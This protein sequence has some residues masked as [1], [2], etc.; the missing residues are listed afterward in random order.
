MSEPII[1]NPG[2]AVQAASM[3]SAIRDDGDA[4]ETMPG[5]IRVKR[6]TRMADPD[7]AVD[8]VVKSVQANV[9]DVDAKLLTIKQGRGGRRLF[10]SNHYPTLA[11]YM[12]APQIRKR[13][14]E[15]FDAGALNDLNDRIRANVKS[16]RQLRE[17]RAMGRSVV[18]AMVK[19]GKV[20]KKVLE[21][22]FYM[23]LYSDEAQAAAGQ[24]TVFP[25]QDVIL[26]STSSPSGK[27]QLWVD[28]LDMHR[29]S[30]EAA[31]RNPIGK[32]ICDIIPQFVLGR[33]LVGDIKSKP[34]QEAW[35]E[36]Y[37]RERLRSRLRVFLKE[38]L[39][40]GEI[41]LR[42]FKRPDGLV[43]RS[44]DPSSIWDVVTSPEDFEDVYY[45]HQQYNISNTSPVPGA[46]IYPAKLVIRQIPAP[47]ID[48]FKIN[49]VSSEKRGRSQLYSILGYLLRFKEFANDRVL[50]NK[51]RAMFALDVSV[52]GGAEDV[53]TAEAQFAI[54]PGPG[55]VLIHNKAVEV[56]FKNANN[57]ANEAKTDAE[58]ILKIIAI[59]AG[60][61]EQFL[62]V[63]GA[64][65]RAGALIQTE[66]DVKNFETYQ[67]IL[68]D[69]LDA[70]WDRLQ[71]A[72]GL[73]KTRE[74]MEW[75]FPGLAQ[76]DRS[77]K[78]K[79]IAFAESMDYFTK[80]RSGTM[81]AKEFGVT[82]YDYAAEKKSIEAE[83][84]EAPFITSALQQVPKQA[85][86]PM[87]MMNE[88]GL[89][90][91]LKPGAKPPGMP[92]ATDKP[93]VTQTSAEMGFSAKNLSGRGLATTPASLSRSTFTRGGE[94]KSIQGQ[95][96][97]SE[98]A[99]PRHVWNDAARVKAAATRRTNAVKRREQLTPA[100]VHGAGA[101]DPDD[102]E[103]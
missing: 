36:F 40:Y 23:G 66:P 47:E 96:S 24:R 99:R 81:V 28:Y 103:A 90:Q 34:H 52:E 75:S 12:K 92:G 18:E 35:D 13:V 42:Y 21:S 20:D 83:R 69:I 45:Y 11:A 30:W 98:S 10:E 58:M 1:T 15:R 94:K 53:N 33:G 82:E 70:A 56:E 9:T 8:D 60:V 95:R 43:V 41:F 51:M 16:D 29:K 91:D 57:N 85:P 73:S 102:G 86:D 101:G 54:P 4:P 25:L 84:G 27:Q 64:S 5:F 50:L 55:A 67:E 17:A 80:E 48:H 39:I 93:G 97:T 65:T 71:A 6:L 76:E 59:G 74:K 46:W 88:P 37:K 63:S 77:A 22:D 26:P 49:H 44:L 87:A 62:G 89:G 72:K 78:L 7:K 31:T 19:S 61:S 14:L 32:R 2:A 68:Q 100:I 38:L 3:I 79:D